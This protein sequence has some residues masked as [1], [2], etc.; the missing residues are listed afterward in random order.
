MQ[1]AIH[2]YPKQ[3]LNPSMTV[4]NGG[5]RPPRTAGDYGFRHMGEES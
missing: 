1:R 3:V 5:A 2:F 4:F